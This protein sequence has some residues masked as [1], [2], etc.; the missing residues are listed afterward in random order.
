MWR[1]YSTL[2]MG[3]IYVFIFADSLSEVIPKQTYRTGSGVQ[4]SRSVRRRT[5]EKNQRK[6]LHTVIFIPPPHSSCQI[7]PRYD[8]WSKCI[9]ML[10]RRH[11]PCYIT[12]RSAR[13]RCPRFQMYLFSSA[14]EG[15]APGLSR[16]LQAVPRMKRWLSVCVWWGGVGCS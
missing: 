1:H 12:H 7:L 11:V 8:P 16:S 13:Q 5:A 2:N 10:I 9:T 6:C 3:K 14:C 4:M 15:S